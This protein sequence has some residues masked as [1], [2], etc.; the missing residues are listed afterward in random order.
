MTHLMQLMI[1]ENQIL[2]DKLAG[3]NLSFEEIVFKK[4]ESEMSLEILNRLAKVAS[5]YYKKFLDC[6]HELNDTKFAKEDLNYRLVKLT[7]AKNLIVFNQEKLLEQVR[8]KLSKSK[9]E[10]H[11]CNEEKEKLKIRLENIQSS[12]QNLVEVYEKL[13]KRSN[14][15]NSR[16]QSTR[17]EKLCNNCKKIYNEEENFNWSCKVHT[18]P[19]NDFWWC[20]GKKERNAPGCKICKHE[21]RDD[22]AAQEEGI[23]EIKAF[24]SVIVI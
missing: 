4:A 24:C 7:D 21:S 22:E 23:R 8:E 1:I 15:A 18:S 11:L 3:L 17:I 16:N 14:L 20:C 13:R 5:E 12:H 6:E 2:K 19:F 10:L 9:E